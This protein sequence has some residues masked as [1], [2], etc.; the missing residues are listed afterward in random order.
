MNLNNHSIMKLGGLVLLVMVLFGL[1]LVHSIVDDSSTNLVEAKKPSADACMMPGELNIT[2]GPNAGKTLKGKLQ[3]VFDPTSGSNKVGG[4]FFVP[5][6]NKLDLCDDGGNAALSKHLEMTGEVV[7][8]EV[9]MTFTLPDRTQTMVGTGSFDLEEAK[10][11]LKGSEVEGLLEGPEISD[12]GDWIFTS[13]K[14]IKAAAPYACFSGCSY[15]GGT[16]A[17]CDNLCGTTH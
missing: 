2:A 17:E 6:F 1:S 5:Q 15:A 13:I 4:D 10:K 16:D 12:S 8:G 11:C 9:T 7:A 14:I 3:M